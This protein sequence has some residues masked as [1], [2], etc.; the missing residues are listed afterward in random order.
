MVM[1]GIH[2]AIYLILAAFTAAA[3]GTAEA[4]QV[5]SAAATP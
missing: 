5:Q 1:M 4:N 3:P 2:I